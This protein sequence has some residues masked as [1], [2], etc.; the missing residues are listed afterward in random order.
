MMLMMQGMVWRQVVVMLVMLGLL[1]QI[2]EHRN[3]HSNS[4]ETSMLAFIMSSI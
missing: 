1:N 2:R 3:T 4:K